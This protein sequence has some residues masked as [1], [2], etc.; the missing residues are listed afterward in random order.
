MLELCILAWSYRR[1]KA[2]SGCAIQSR[3]HHVSF[4]QN[5]G[6]ECQLQRVPLTVVDGS[7]T[8]AVAEGGVRA[9]GREGV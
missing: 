4:V 1:A 6:F 2:L 8:A 7:A 9:T 3:E 5:V